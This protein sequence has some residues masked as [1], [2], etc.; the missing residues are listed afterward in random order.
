M[1]E[2]LDRFMARANAAYY[3]ARDPFADFTTAPEISQV[4]GEILG[5]WAAVVWELLGAPDPVLLAEAG[6]GRGTLMADALRAIARSSARLSGRRCGCIWS[7]P[8]PVCAHVQAQALPGRDVARRA[9]IR[10]RDGPLLLLGQRVPG[11]LA[12]PAVRPPRT[13][14]D[15]AATSRRARSSSCPRPDPAPARRPRARRGGMP[16]SR[17]CRAAEDLAAPARRAPGRAG[18]GGAVP[19]LRIRAQRRPATRSRRCEGAARPTRSPSPAPPTS[20]RMWIS[21]PSRTPR[22]ARAR[23]CMARFRKAC[24]SRASAC[25]SAPTAWPAA[26]RPRRPPR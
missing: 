18:R 21:P 16:S 25:S 1:P 14:L 13:G 19:R 8:R 10:C 4:F 7:R 2:R 17:R 3:A 26:S 24:S 9:R 23:P 22:G 20:P 6:P 15:G 5:L 11:R 12:H